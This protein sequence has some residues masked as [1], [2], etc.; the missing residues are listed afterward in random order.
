[1]LNQKKKGEEE[2]LPP[3]KKRANQLSKMF[4]ERIQ[5]KK[6]ISLPIV[7]LK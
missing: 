6:C 1:L 4:K 2:G 7:S 3:I 5:E